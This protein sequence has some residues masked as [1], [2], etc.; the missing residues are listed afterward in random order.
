MDW[1]AAILKLSHVALAMVLVAGIIGRWVTLRRA[2][3]SEDIETTVR[4]TEASHPF[5]RMVVTSS[6]LILPAGFLTAY[7]QGYEW[8]GLTTGWML[9]S[10]LIY[11]AATLLVPTVFLPRGRAFAVALAEARAAGSVTP[12]LHAAFDDRQVR[13]ARWF[14]IGGIAVIVALMVLKPF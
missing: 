14:E 2:R 8:L 1:P 3:Q 7:A 10:T 11:V 6:L 5:E 4:F 12:A 9:V 13:M